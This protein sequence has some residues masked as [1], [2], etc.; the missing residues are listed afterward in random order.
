MN[1]FLWIVIINGDLLTDHLRVVECQVLYNR[2]S[3]H[4]YYKQLD[5]NPHVLHLKIK[6]HNYSL[7]GTQ[8]SIFEYSWDKINSGLKF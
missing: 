3:T 8:I 5:Y 7:V 4:D 1:V 2:N 6:I